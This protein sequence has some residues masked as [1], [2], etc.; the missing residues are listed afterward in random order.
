MWLDQKKI[1]ELHAAVISVGLDRR[2]LLSG[3]HAAFVASLPLS[4]S[5]SAQF[6]S[7]LAQLNSVEQ[8]S[9]GSVPL[10][11]WLRTAAHLAG[12][13]KEGRV[14]EEAS[15]LVTRASRAKSVEPP[16]PTMAASTQR[17][18]AVKVFLSAA[19]EDRRFVD[20]LAR[21]LVVL[22]RQGAIDLSSHDH[23]P[24][25]V[26][27]RAWIEEHLDAAELV[28]LMV[29]ADFLAGEETFAEL[30]RALALRDEQ[31]TRVVPVIARTVGLESTPLAG[32]TRLPRSGVPIASSRDA[33]ATYTEIVGDLRR[34]I[35]DLRRQPSTPEG[36]RP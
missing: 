34:I 12:P 21:H 5:L 6:L 31:G 15:S 32:L 17:T 19:A 26:D 22:S 8:L 14:F 16:R 29:S 13:R 2:A 30:E 25:G 9:D 18:G 4:S 11:E 23:M 20:A 35:A 10:L 24:P 27:R 3:I 1:H 7:D 33:D 28:V 36:N